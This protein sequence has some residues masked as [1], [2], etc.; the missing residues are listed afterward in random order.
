[1][2]NWVSIL[3]SIFT[4][5][6]SRGSRIECHL[7]F[8]MVPHSIYDPCCPLP[9]SKLPITLSLSP[10]FFRSIVLGF[11][12]ENYNIQEKLQTVV[13][14]NC[15]RYVNKKANSLCLCRSLPGAMDRRFPFL[16][17]GLPYLPNK[18]DC[19]AYFSMNPLRIHRILKQRKIEPKRTTALVVQFT[20]N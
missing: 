18:I 14:Q 5:W 2:K 4:S 11:S 19:W 6:F 16:P 8:I 10:K 13:M 3:D 17:Y 15:G 12:W 20:T 9:H 7:T 1:M